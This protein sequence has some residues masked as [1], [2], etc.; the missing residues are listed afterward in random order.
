MRGRRVLDVG[1]DSVWVPRS[2]SATANDCA[3]PTLGASLDGRRH[4]DLARSRHTERRFGRDHYRRS[5]CRYVRSRALGAGL[6]WAGWFEVGTSPLAHSG[7]GRGIPGVW[8]CQGG[9]MPRQS[10]LVES[11]TS[12]PRDISTDVRACGRTRLLLDRRA[13]AV[14]SVFGRQLGADAF[15]VLGQGGV[16]VVLGLAERVVRG[17]VACQHAGEGVDDR[18]ADAGGVA[19]HRPCGDRVRRA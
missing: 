14:A 2:R 7:V 18:V 15:V 6:K 12:S 4:R 9:W 11:V 8:A 10:G 16:G 19:Q 1:C 17:P 5:M 13:R 3:S